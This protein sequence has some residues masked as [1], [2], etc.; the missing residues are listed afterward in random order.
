M[1]YK[2]ISTRLKIISVLL[3]LNQKSFL[4]AHPKLNSPPIIPTGCVVEQP[5]NICRISLFHSRSYVYFQGPS[6][7]VKKKSTIAFHLTMKPQNEK[8][9]VDIHASIHKTLQGVP[10]KEKNRA[11]DGNQ[12]LKSKE[13]SCDGQRG[14]GCALISFERHETLFFHHAWK[15]GR[16]KN[17][18]ANNNICTPSL[19]ERNWNSKSAVPNA[20]NCS[21]ER[22]AENNVK[23]WKS[24]FRPP[25][26]YNQSDYPLRSSKWI[27]QI[28]VEMVRLWNIKR[29]RWPRTKSPTH[30]IM[31]YWRSKW[32][33]RGLQI[34]QN[35]QKGDKSQ[36]H[37]EE[38]I[39]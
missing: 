7:L 18:G 31:R 37:R 33:Y 35:T 17:Y 38:C 30:F 26:I 36:K 19:P 11:N 12:R 1:R 4:T 39:F 34:S 3:R 32:Q 5:T 2:N 10:T 22:K 28:W 14:K 6:W 9:S 20:S 16:Q 25:W 23:E 21:E 24:S 8:R 29:R 27:N 15:A 13:C